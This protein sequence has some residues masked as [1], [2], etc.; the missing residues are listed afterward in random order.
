MK[1]RCKRLVIGLVILFMLAACQVKPEMDTAVYRTTLNELSEELIATTLPLAQLMAQ[2]QTPTA[3]LVTQ[4]R[5][6]LTA[7]QNELDALDPPPAELAVAHQHLTEAIV[8]FQQAYAHLAHNLEIG[9][10]MPFDQEFLTL[11]THGGEAIHQMATAL[12]E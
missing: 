9:V 4:T 6:R 1:S 7:V 8:Q 5:V 11:A 3:A 12:N 10:S 2:G